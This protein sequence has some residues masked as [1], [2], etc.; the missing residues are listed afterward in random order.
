MATQQLPVF[1][2]RFIAGIKPAEL[3]LNP[4]V[5]EY[6]VYDLIDGHGSWRFATER[7]A[8]EKAAWYNEFEPLGPGYNTP[9]LAMVRLAGALGHRCAS[10]VSERE[11]YGLT[12]VELNALWEERVRRDWEENPEYAYGVFLGISSWGENAGAVVWTTGSGR[13][14]IQVTDISV[15]LSCW[16]GTTLETA[17]CYAPKGATEEA[18][19]EFWGEPLAPSEED[20]SNRVIAVEYR[21]NEGNWTADLLGFNPRYVEGGREDRASY[22]ISFDRDY[23]GGALSRQPYLPDAL[24]GIFQQELDR[25][26]AAKREVDA[27][28]TGVPASVMLADGSQCDAT[29]R[30]IEPGAYVVVAVIDGDV[31]YGASSPNVYCSP[32]PPI[33]DVVDFKQGDLSEYAVNRIYAS[34]YR[35]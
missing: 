31:H 2:V 18:E 27:F 13:L 24:A 30:A 10:Y 15:T 8:A 29:F 20:T 32:L 3:R 28:E 25:R 11:A 7:E 34:G 26:E 33:G 5:I 1:Q 17:S 6:E 21:L 12:P 4:D 22:V 23:F 14:S 16:S 19:W 9:A 35:R